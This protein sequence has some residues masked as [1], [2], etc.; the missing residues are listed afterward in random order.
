MPAFSA[1]GMSTNNGL[2][3]N[4]IINVILVLIA[5]LSCVVNATILLI[6]RFVSSNCRESSKQACRVLLWVPLQIKKT[7]PSWRNLQDCKLKNHKTRA[8]KNEFP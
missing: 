7:G 3:M 5:L 2:L 4:T 1:L 6:P 8:L